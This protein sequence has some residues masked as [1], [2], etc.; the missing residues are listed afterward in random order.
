[1]G[2]LVLALFLQKYSPAT[3]V[4]IYESTDKLTDVG[5][6]IGMFPRVWE[7]VRFLGLE[8][9]LLEVTGTSKDTPRE[10]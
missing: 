7:I 2:G 6:G 8:D 9:D 4:N 5:V 1:M 10:C 3:Q